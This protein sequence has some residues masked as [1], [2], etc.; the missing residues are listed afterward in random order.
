MTDEVISSRP[1]PAARQMRQGGAGQDEAGLEVDG[2]RQVQRRLV[3]GLD[4]L[5]RHGGGV[6]HHDVQPSQ[7]RRGIVHHRRGRAGAGEVH[8]EEDAAPA[9]RL[10]QPQRLQPMRLG[11][12]RHRHLRALGGEAQGD[13]A[14]DAAPGS[15]HDRGT[16]GKAGLRHSVSFCQ[17]SSS[18]PVPA[19]KVEQCRK[20]IAASSVMARSPSRA[21]WRLGCGGDK[22]N[23]KRF[24]TK[25]LRH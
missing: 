13:G 18:A 7:P 23:K 20:T 16:A 8:G 15:G 6:V 9:R 19:R 4:H 11:A 17:V 14:P 21:A 1:P 10:D 5:A 25:A 12:G 22:A 3:H 24:T 2:E